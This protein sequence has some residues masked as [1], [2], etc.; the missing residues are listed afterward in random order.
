MKKESHHVD[1]GYIFVTREVWERYLVIKY[2]NH[3]DVQGY[4]FVTRLL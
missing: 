2:E 3:H 1:V 4:I